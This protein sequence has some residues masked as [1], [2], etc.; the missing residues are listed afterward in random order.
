MIQSQLEDSLIG[1]I[2]RDSTA[3]EA[4]EK[5][6]GI[7][8]KSEAPVPILGQT[9]QMIAEVASEPVVRPKRG[10]PRKGEQRPPAPVIP[11]ERQSGQ[12]LSQV[13]TELPQACSVG[14]KKN[15]SGYRISW[16]GYELH[17]DTAC[18]GVIIGAALTAAAAHDSGTCQWPCPCRS[19]ALS[20]S[21]TFTN[22]STHAYCSTIIRDY[23]INQGRVPLTDHNPRA[24]KKNATGA[25]MLQRNNLNPVKPRTGS[26]N[27]VRV[28]HMR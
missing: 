5:V 26:R 2:S 27:S 1:H 23:A 25:M 8:T 11:L 12:N 13:L 14:T 24:G 21:I 3:I 15:A 19:S 20:G 6:V 16:R 18:C 4:L 17:L 10:R 9:P 28:M 22:S 7:S